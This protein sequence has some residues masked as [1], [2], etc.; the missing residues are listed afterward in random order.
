ME[1][2]EYD[3]SLVWQKTSDF[4]LGA[5]GI[6]A[7]SVTTGTGTTISYPIYD[8]HGN[9]I[10]TL[11]KAGAGYTFT[12]ERSFDAWGVIRLGAQTGDPKGRYCASLGHKQDDESGLVY[13]RARYYEPGSGRFVSEDPDRN[14]GNWLV[15]ADNSPTCLV[16]QSGKSPL[17][18]L[19]LGAFFAAATAVL[20]LWNPTDPVLKAM[21]IVISATLGAIGFGIKICSYLAADNTKMGAGD[22]IGLGLAY[23]LAGVLA[24]IAVGQLREAMELM[25][26]GS[27]GQRFVADSLM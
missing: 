11:S 26:D 15:Y 9:M 14:G 4:A 10:S 5:R 13:M 23:L 2:V 18:S 22:L 24:G 12:A 7:I 8:A 21:K 20:C 25:D 16:D 1:D 6:D 3:G 17:A 19:L 27:D